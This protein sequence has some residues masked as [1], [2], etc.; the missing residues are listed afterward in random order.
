MDAGSTGQSIWHRV[1]VFEA[2]EC[3]SVLQGYVYSLGGGGV[4]LVVVLYKMI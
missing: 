1:V 2:G 4:G 3:V